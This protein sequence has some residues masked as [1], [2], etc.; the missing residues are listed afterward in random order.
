MYGFSEDLNLKHLVGTE[1]VEVSIAAY[2]LFLILEP[3]N[4]IRIE[5]KWVLLDPQGHVFDEG[6]QQEPKDAYRVHVLLQKKIMAYTVLDRETLDL[7]FEG[8]WHFRIIDDS[9]PYES[10]SITPDIYI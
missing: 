8:G 10:A 7:E 3:K 4:N 1:L 6:Y 2:C 9:G 5:G